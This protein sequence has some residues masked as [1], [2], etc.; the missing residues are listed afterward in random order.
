MGRGLRLVAGVA[1]WR[2]S[3]KTQCVRKYL[4]NAVRFPIWS[5]ATSYA[6][7]SISITSERSD[8]PSLT[9]CIYTSAATRRYETAELAELLQKVFN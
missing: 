1:E 8:M 9:H 3:S 7:R 2:G 6:P 4:K 5:R